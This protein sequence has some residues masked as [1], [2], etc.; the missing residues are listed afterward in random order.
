[1]RYTNAHQTVRWAVLAV[2]LALLLLLATG[3]TSVASAQ[4][5]RGTVVEDSS[6]KPISDV[7]VVMLARDGGAII[8]S[9]RS[10]A[11]GEF[12]LKAPEPGRYTLRATRIGYR[13]VT[14]ND[15]SI[16]AGDV[17]D[18]TVN[19]SAVAVPMRAVVV[20]DR[21]RLSNRELLGPLGFDFRRQTR[22]GHFVDSATISR[23]RGA[24]FSDIV[25]G[26]VPFTQFVLG[27]FGERIL[28][29]RV[30]TRLCAPYLFVNGFEVR[31][32][33]TDILDGYD[34]QRFY[35]IEAYRGL[36]IPFEFPSIGRDPAKDRCGAVAV[37]T[38]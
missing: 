1:M 4:I 32:N 17:L 25:R 30:G 5:V 18:V 16:R 33:G 14:S 24:P 8:G 27:R 20:T 3:M 19:M 34:S 23:Y 11:T 10:N 2:V 13:P 6:G 36:G 37:W 9:S 26:E 12:V 22:S 21:S 28:A 29:M 15:L 35:G 31:S 38:L 7:G